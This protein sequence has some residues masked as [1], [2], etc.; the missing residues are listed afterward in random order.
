MLP[1]LIP[2]PFRRRDVSKLPLIVAL[3]VS[4]V[5]VVAAIAIVA[6]AVRP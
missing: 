6:S 3:I 2:N 1:S 5:L 4:L